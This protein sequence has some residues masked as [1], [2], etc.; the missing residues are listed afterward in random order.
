VSPGEAWRLA[1]EQFE[2]AKTPL[3]VR[4]EYFERFNEYRETIK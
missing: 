1:E 2:A 3:E 4:E